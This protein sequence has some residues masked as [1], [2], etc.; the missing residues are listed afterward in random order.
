MQCF[1]CSQNV[2]DHDHFGYTEDECPLF[3]DTQVRQRRAI[4]TAQEDAVHERL[5]MD[6]VL[7]EDDL[8]IDPNLRN[9][10][11]E[12]SA[13][14][15]VEELGLH[16]RR[17]WLDEVI[18]VLRIFNRPREHE[19]QEREQREQQEL[20]E[21]EREEREQAEAAEQARREAERARR[22]AEQSEQQKS[23]KRQDRRDRKRMNRERQAQEQFR[24][25]NV[26][27]TRAS[28]SP[29]RARHR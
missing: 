28:K 2:D 19:R 9:L 5:Q 22:E 11:E 25:S 20:E 21:R 29:K 16:P 17:H 23:Q 10:D 8:L 15:A 24:Q 18:E 3:D 27:W 7:A 6:T 4:A 1:V 26:V 14:N 12:Q 13:D